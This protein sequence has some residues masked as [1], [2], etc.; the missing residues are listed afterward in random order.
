MKK[1]PHCG[2]M[3]LDTTILCPHCNKDIYSQNVEENLP[4]R[5]K[6]VAQIEQTLFDFFNYENNEDGTITILSLK[7]KNQL[8]IVI[9][10]NVV[11]I[12]ASAFENSEVMSVKL[13]EGLLKIGDCAF[14]NCK[15]LCEINLPDSLQIIG[16]Y[17]FDGDDLLE[18]NIPKSVKK[19]GINVIN[20]EIMQKKMASYYKLLS[21]FKRVLLN[22]SNS[23]Q[24]I[25]NFVIENY[26]LTKYVGEKNCSDETI[27]IPT[28]ALKI[29]DHAF[30]ECNW[31]KQ[32]VILHGLNVID[33]YA[34]RNCINL[35]RVSVSD[36]VLEIGGGE[37]FDG[38]VCLENI[39]VSLHN[40]RFKSI[41]GNLFN[42]DGTELICYAGGKT[43]KSFLIDKNIQRIH[44]SAFHESRF[45]E[46][47]NVEEN[48]N[49]FKSIDGNLYSK[50]GNT[51]MH[52][53]IGK[54]EESFIIPDTVTSI[55]DSAFYN[56]NYLKSIIVSF[57]VNEIG[58]C[59]FYG[60]ENLKIVKLPDRVVKIGGY[61]FACCKNLQLINYSGT[62]EQWK[63]LVHDSFC[64]FE[65]DK[66]ICVKCVDGELVI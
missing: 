27:I 41:D 1:C 37:V 11:L 2:K 5:E 4:L 10:D 6:G 14:K 35:K 23:E 36:S 3:I 62:K 9:P 52:Y 19:V 22:K 58:D 60:C 57:R 26:V 38:C 39:D 51:L 8:R 20:P 65:K 59:A 15:N 47:I 28:S 33:V 50:D 43:N 56:C 7:N 55:G 34:F 13:P 49:F 66:Q 48:N 21:I 18:I 17:A 42:K 25:K 30:Y 40:K 12:A 54:K 64:V 32:V 63:K 31:I 44:Y 16:D 24:N 61:A 29:K 46:N 45:L 53:S